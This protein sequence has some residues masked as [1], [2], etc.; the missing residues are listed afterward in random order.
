MTTALTLLLMRYGRAK[1]R[2]VQ[3]RM[4]ARDGGLGSTIALRHRDQTLATA[5][6]ARYHSFLRS[7][8]LPIP[9]PAAEAADPVAADDA[10]RSAAD[11]LRGRT[12]DP[13]KFALLQAENRDFG[14]RRN[15]LG[16]RPL[17]LALTLTSLAADLAILWLSPGNGTQR[18]AAIILAASLVAV[19]LAWIF[20]VTT[21]F[22]SDASRSYTDQLYACCDIL[23][24]TPATKAK[25]KVNSVAEPKR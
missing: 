2:A 4:I 3:E 24:D 25:R 22:V 19:S 23:Q 15:L 17:G 12:R 13:K 18:T 14:F 21:A 16:L 7:K 6:K 11:W 8:G 1:G 20:M 10:Y 9:D 5:S